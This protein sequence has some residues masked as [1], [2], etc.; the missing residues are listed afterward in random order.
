[1]HDNDKA[2]M[3]NLASGKNAIFTLILT[4]LDYH[5]IMQDN[6]PNLATLFVP[7]PMNKL[8]DSGNIKMDI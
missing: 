8:K 4:A 3:P 7:H 6:L 2:Q 5:Y 1:M